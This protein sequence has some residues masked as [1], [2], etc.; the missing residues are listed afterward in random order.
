[1]H[2]KL[3]D[4]RKEELIDLILKEQKLRK[5]AE[6]EIE[7]LKKE[8]R[9]YKN[10]NTPPSAHYHLKPSAASVRR[11]RRRG[12]P[13]GH[14]GAT[15]PRVQ[16]EESK[17]ITAEH[18]PRCQST[19]IAV[20]GAREQQIEDLPP[21]IDPIIRAIERDLCRCNA[22]DLSFT[23]RDGATPLKGRFGIN[24]IVLVLMLRFI[25]RGV[26][27]KTASFLEAGFMVRL[28]PATVQAII[29]RAAEAAEPEYGC[30]KAKIRHS[31]VLYI[32]ETS[33][34]VLGRNWWAWVFR[35]PTEKLIVIRPSRGAGVIREIIGEAYSGI[36]HC[37]CWRAYD[38]LTS[39]SLQRCW[40]HLLRKSAELAET[41]P[42]RRIHDKLKALFKEI[43]DF[44][45][46]RRTERQRIKK[47]ERMT[48]ELKELITR[49]ARYEA[50]LPVVNYIRF[51]LESWFT[52]VRYPGVE[53]TNNL[54]EQSIRETVI[55]RKIIGAFRSTKGPQ[56][57]E[58]LASLI[59]TWQIQ[60]KDIRAEL[61]RMLA[62]N[63]C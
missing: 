50:C 45:S 57:Y 9:K 55:V 49:Y 7:R 58:T 46:D 2:H 8:L 14:L 24:L 21:R 10:P 53:P 12:A 26:L 52:C 13:D 28:A 38:L 11:F 51:H 41:A 29:G 56:A 23:A 61:R 59:A 36:V 40:A 37:D 3:L 32:D 34:R 54:A 4:K 35:T 15:R 5:E 31:P 19:D 16:A 33:F 47:Y 1:M 42:G 25:V 60:N 30:L 48:E 20:V 43:E 18:C 62:Q 39:A 27:R 44:N 22:C 17:R 63:L 6:A